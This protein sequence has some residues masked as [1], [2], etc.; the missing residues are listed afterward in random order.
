LLVF[1]APEGGV[2]NLSNFWKRVWHPALDAAELGYR[3]LRE[4]RHTFAT[5]ALAAGVPIEWISKELGRANI[6]T[7]LKHYARFL[8]AADARALAALDSFEPSEEDRH[9]RKADAFGDE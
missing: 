8:P 7:T 9:G 5:L 6:R 1:P 3:P 4:M 2:V